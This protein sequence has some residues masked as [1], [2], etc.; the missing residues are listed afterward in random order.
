MPKANTVFT[1]HSC[2]AVH[3]K[4]SG[5]CDACGEWNTLVEETSSAAPGGLAAPK[6]SSR[7]AGK[8]E[9]T[10]L[11]AVEDAP[12]RHMIGVDELDRVFGGGV[13]PSSATLIGGDPGIGKSTLLLQVAARLAR[14]G[15][16]TVYVSG[17]EAAAQIQD[18]ARRLKVSESPVELATETDLRK[19]MSALKSANPDFVVIDSIQTMW[20]DSLEAAP[21]SVAQVRA[22]AQELTRWAKKSGAALILVGHVTKEGQI[23]GPRVVEHMVDTVFYFEGER[24]HQ[25]RILRAVKNRFGPTD[26]IGIFEMHQYGLAPAREP[27]ALFLSNEDETSGGTAVFAAMEGSRPVLAEVQAL[28]AAS[29]YGTPRRSIVGWDANRLAMVLAVLEARCGVSLAGRD[30][31]L[32]VAG[33]YRM[34]E[35]AGDLAAAAAL[36]TSLADRPPPEKSVFFGEVA[37]SGAIRPVARMDQRLKEAQRLGFRNAFVPEGSTGSFEG[38]TVKP[39]SRLSDLVDLIGPDPEP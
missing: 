14:N 23:A 34:A 35:P 37:L 25:F 22:C 31:Y 2:G 21:G 26:E 36:L 8:A 19:V 20:S 3:P 10:T 5:R 6:S 15:L 38:L 13:V 29:A 7:K 4:W 18:R 16:S 27:S 39:L 32:S 11:N 12:T 28:V 24:G 33:G 17:E 30:V 9:F 1:C